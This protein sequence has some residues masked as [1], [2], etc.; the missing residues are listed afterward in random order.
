MIRRLRRAVGRVVRP[1]D[2]LESAAYGR[3]FAATVLAT[4]FTS[5]APPSVDRFV[6]RA[7]HAVFVRTRQGRVE[8]VARNIETATRVVHGNISEESRREARNYWLMRIEIRYGEARGAGPRPW[9]PDVRVEGVEHISEGLAR[10]SGVILWRL[11]FTSPVVVN[12]GLRQAGFSFVHLTSTEH[13]GANR[14]RFSRRISAPFSN[15]AEAR[16]VAKSV[17]RP[18][19]GNL[20]YLKQLRA[21][22]ENNAVVTIVG[23]I[24]KALHTEVHRVANLRREIPTGAPSLAYASG[25]TLHT[26]VAVR[27]G[28]F[29]YRLSIGPDIS[30][31]R[32]GPK[33]VARRAATTRFAEDFERHLLTSTD[34]SAIWGRL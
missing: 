1:A 2:L 34:S 19:T 31:A 20:A 29:R 25:A 21:E 4:A 26:C 5:I 28:P 9:S 11:S 7:V 30:E 18:S 14:S 16:L 6:C 23:D 15:R 17:V 32:E 8:E 3:R 12:T 27:E 13:R 24:T 22:L 10:G 33:P